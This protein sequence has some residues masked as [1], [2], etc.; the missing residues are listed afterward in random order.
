MFQVTSCPVLV[1]PGNY[2]I[3]YKCHQPQYQEDEVV[4]EPTAQFGGLHREI[5]DP[6]WVG[7]D[8]EDERGECG[9]DAHDPEEQSHHHPPHAVRRLCVDKLES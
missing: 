3:Q 6:V 1:P 4:P 5:L 2:H 7:K 9:E 8:E